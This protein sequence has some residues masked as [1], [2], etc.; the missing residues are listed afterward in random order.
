MKN[1]TIRIVK[2]IIYIVGHFVYR[3]YGCAAKDAFFVMCGCVIA[4]LN[5]QYDKQ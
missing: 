4:Q 5:M 1:V 3:L 2:Y